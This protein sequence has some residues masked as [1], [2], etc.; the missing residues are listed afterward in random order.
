MVFNDELIWKYFPKTINLSRTIEI[1]ICA[2]VRRHPLIKI[3]WA[4]CTAKAIVRH[5][6]WYLS[7]VFSDIF[8]WTDRMDD[9]PVNSIDIAGRCH[10]ID[11]QFVCVCP[12]SFENIFPIFE[13]CMNFKNVCDYYFHFHFSVFVFVFHHAEW[14]DTAVDKIC[15]NTEK[16]CS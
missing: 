1:C 7:K 16:S 11:I 3:R 9:V 5:L 15:L 6:P 2:P 14:I 10:F 4:M 12:I 8:S 13:E